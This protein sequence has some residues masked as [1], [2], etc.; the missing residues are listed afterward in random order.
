MNTRPPFKGTF[1]ELVDQ[2]RCLYAEMDRDYDRAA[3]ASGFACNGCE[4]N[5]CRSLFY[6]HT[7]LEYF[8]LHKAMADLPCARQQ[9]IVERATAYVRS[10]SESRP[11]EE[12]AMCPLNE[13]G[14]CILY[15]VRPMICRLHGIP[16]EFMP[17]GHPQRLE[18]GCRDFY[19]QCGPQEKH[20]L[21]RT[22]HYFELA[23]L[24]AEFKRCLGLN[25]KMKLTVAEILLRK[26][27]GTIAELLDSLRSRPSEDA[28]NE[29]D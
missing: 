4:D 14:R 21:D 26:P 17:P 2:A 15:S 25:Q 7:Y 9:E 27:V 23:R 24:E 10:V 19:Q 29:T 1:S 8:L 12:Q 20:R 6:H 3:G 16:N 28:D 13:K 22:P 18:A 5:C 11:D